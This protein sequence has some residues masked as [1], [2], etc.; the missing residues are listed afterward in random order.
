[1]AIKEYSTTYSGATPVQ[2]ADPIT[3]SQPD[4]DDE[5]APGVGDGDETRSSQMETIR[6]KL[7]AAAK[8][9]GDS[10]NN[11]A[12]SLRDI[13]N[14]VSGGAGFVRLVERGSAPGNLANIGF[15]YTKEV[16]GSTELFYMDE[17]GNEDQ[18]T[19]GTSTDIKVK[20]SA[21]DTTAGYL[22]DELTVANG[23]Q[24]NIQNPGAD[25]N[26]Q[27]S[28]SY[29][30]AA[31]TVCEGDDSRLPSQDE[32]DAL[33]GTDGTPSSSN[34]YVTDSDARNSDSRAPIGSASGDLA[35]SYPS[36]SVAALTTTTGP[37]SLVVGAVADGEYLRRT[38]ATVVGGPGGSAS[39]LSTKGDL[40]AH[41]G[42]SDVR[43][44]VGPDGTLPVADSSESIGIKWEANA[45][46]AIGE[47]VEM[48]KQIGSGTFSLSNTSWTDTP[49]ISEQQFTIVN[50]GTYK[51]D[52]LF[53][54]LTG[55]VPTS[56]TAR[57]RLVFD[58][59]GFGGFTE[60]TIGHDDVSWDLRVDQNSGANNIEYK[61]I[62][63][64]VTLG[65]GTHKVKI[66]YKKTSTNAARMSTANSYVVR[67]TLIS[68]ASANGL[69]KHEDTIASP[70]NIVGD[71]GWHDLTGSVHTI[72]TIEGEEI[73]LDF[74]GWAELTTMGGSE[75]LFYHSIIVDG[76]TK[77]A[78]VQRVDYADARINLSVSRKYGPLS[79]GSHTVKIMYR[80][81]T[82]DTFDVYSSKFTVTQFR[83]GYAQEQLVP[84]FERDSGDTSVINAIAGP[85]QGDKFLLKLN[86]GRYYS[87]SATL[88]CD[89][90]T[91]GEG[92][93]DT[94]ETV[95]VGLWNLFAVESSTEG[96][97]GLV[98]SQATP[99]NGP[100]SHQTAYLY[101]WTIRVT[102]ISG[103][104]IEEFRQKGQW[105]FP[106]DPSGTNWRCMYDLRST[107]PTADTWY[108]LNNVGCPGS[109]TLLG[110]MVPLGN[111]IADMARMWGWMYC[112]STAGTKYVLFNMAP[113]NPPAM[114]AAGTQGKGFFTFRHYATL[115]SPD[116]HRYI[117]HTADME[118]EDSISIAYDYYAATGSMRTYIHCLGYRN[119]MYPGKIAATLTPTVTPQEQNV[120]YFQRAAA[121]ASLINAIEAPNKGTDWILKLSDGRYY[122]ATS[123][124]C[125][126]D[127]TGEGGRDATESQAVGLWNIFAVRSTTLQQFSLVMSQAAPSAG[128]PS[129]QD[130]YLYLWTTRCTV[131]GPPSSFETFNQKGKWYFYA[132][133]HNNNLTIIQ[134]TS[135]TAPTTDQWEDLN[136][137]LAQ[138]SNTLLGAMVPLTIADKA[139]IWGHM[140]SDSTNVDKLLEIILA[141]GDPP[142]YSADAWRLMFM[143]DW[144]SG[145]DRIYTTNIVD[146]EIEGSIS[147]SYRTW[148][149][150]GMST[151]LYLGCRGYRN[152]MYPGV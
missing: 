60:Q 84:V 10:A 104:V 43:F 46:A 119:A 93:R 142:S 151:N 28:P 63:S 126:I 4:L 7:Q 109:V 146:I 59:G 133:P 16:S 64:E 15:L 26:L 115:P 1:M 101:L 130:G 152:S 112:D 45:M 83:G 108:D 86:D 128:P 140:Y 22:N 70:Y 24:K 49:G 143:N 75:A 97:F 105:Y 74:S 3:G 58:A 103:T 145:T 62:P 131:A 98:L 117:T 149:G 5:S 56:Y 39:P 90:D 137:P 123:L 41:D 132:S 48:L 38:G 23:I 52:A 150:A 92:G 125:D 144:V 148:I 111:G 124:T 79:A 139:Q 95:A 33:V 113:G 57:F 78:V 88:T 129:H 85:N 30:S 99:G 121:D 106:K 2:D 40:Y 31:N 19:P 6:D 37:T 25:E 44:P 73:A 68:G 77:A 65:R 134:D 42:V 66:Q 96:Q 21:A 17:A 53:T 18:I 136:D 12:D 69:D 72:D 47:S 29:G 14:V 61:T 87:A 116:D 147:F 13:L 71:S 51:L 82:G 36:P 80:I 76:S 127:S 91:T 114:S 100:P 11:P 8:Y 122:T 50:P 54:I 34:K 55:T 81:N 32:N 27:I 138:G 120:P 135:V 118:I 110:A 89:I 67:G 94:T 20:T 102:A 141:A 9:I 107:P 35:G